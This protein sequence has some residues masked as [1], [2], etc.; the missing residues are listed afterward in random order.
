MRV[1]AARVAGEMLEQ[2]NP[3][4][5]AIHHE[6]PDGPTECISVM[7]QDFK[8][9]SWEAISN[10]PSYSAWLLGSDIWRE[11]DPQNPG[12][13]FLQDVYTGFKTDVRLVFYRL[14]TSRGR[15]VCMLLCDEWLESKTDSHP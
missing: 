14:G 5:R 1:E 12:K 2:L 13:A 7:S 3:R 4:M 10:V 9:L 15:S 6:E 11:T 8:S